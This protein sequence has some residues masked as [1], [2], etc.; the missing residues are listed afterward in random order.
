MKLKIYDNN[1]NITKNKN[2]NILYDYAIKKGLTRSQA[3]KIINKVI[4]KTFKIINSMV[5]GGKASSK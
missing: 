3:S 5:Q 4:G 2:L 1:H